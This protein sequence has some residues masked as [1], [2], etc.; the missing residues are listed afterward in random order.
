MK[1]KLLAPREV[2]RPIV[3]VHHFPRKSRDEI[4]AIEDPWLRELMLGRWKERPH[5]HDLIQLKCGHTKVRV[6]PSASTLW[7][8][9]PCHLCSV[10][11]QELNVRHIRA[12]VKQRRRQARRKKIRLV[13]RVPVLRIRRSK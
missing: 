10:R 12:K 9:M 8:P 6:R 13:A 2:V 5:G 3:R 4:R 1:I 11:E 7:M